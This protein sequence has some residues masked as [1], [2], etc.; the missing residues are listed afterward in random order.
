MSTSFNVSGYNYFRLRDLA[1]LLDFAVIYDEASG[2]ITL[3]FS[4][5]YSE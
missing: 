1:I 4:Q 3:D 5:P 2:Q